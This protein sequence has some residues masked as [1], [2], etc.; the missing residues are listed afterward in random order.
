LLIVAT[1][2]ILTS[3]Q[4]HTPAE[5]TMIIRWCMG[6]KPEWILVQRVPEQAIKIGKEDQSKRA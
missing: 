5:L 4:D 6:V 2:A 1:T 3:L